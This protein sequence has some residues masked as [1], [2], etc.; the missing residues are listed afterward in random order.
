[1]TVSV[2]WN[3]FSKFK[4]HVANMFLIFESNR[5]TDFV[6]IRNRKMS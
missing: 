2:I 1:L 5:E 4:V 3:V 6:L